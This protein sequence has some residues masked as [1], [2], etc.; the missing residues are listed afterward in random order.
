[1]DRP[2]NSILIGPEDSKRMFGVHATHYQLCKADGLPI[3]GGVIPA[4]FDAHPSEAPGISREPGE[5]ADPIY[6]GWQ[7]V[8]SRR[9]RRVKRSLRE[10][11]GD[12]DE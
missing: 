12:D 6:Y 8:E 1:M 11:R 2:L 10:Q 5:P 9:Q 4:K 3:V 7:R